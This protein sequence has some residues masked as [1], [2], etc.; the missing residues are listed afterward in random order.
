MKLSYIFSA[1]NCEYKQFK[2]NQSSDTVF[3]NL[4]V[5]DTVECVLVDSSAPSCRADQSEGV[6]FAEYSTSMEF[7]QWNESFYLSDF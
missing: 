3:H 4:S 5:F 6:D 2:G 7:L 1:S